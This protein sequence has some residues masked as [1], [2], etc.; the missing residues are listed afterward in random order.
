MNILR[1][2]KGY[3][4][5]NKDFIQVDTVNSLLERS[6]KDLITLDPLNKWLPVITTKKLSHQKSWLVN[7][8][9]KIDFK[10]VLMIRPSHSWSC[11][12]SEILQFLYMSSC[13]SFQ[14]VIFFFR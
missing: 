10:G 1:S 13:V 2:S 11:G 3:E 7:K 9:R 4:K 14:S 8:I 5:N 6:V 12:C